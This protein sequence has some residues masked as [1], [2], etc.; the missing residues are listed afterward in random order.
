MIACGIPLPFQMCREDPTG[1][2]TREGGGML[3]SPLFVICSTNL[4]YL[5]SSA[6][7]MNTH[8]TRD[9]RDSPAYS[10]EQGESLRRTR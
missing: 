6:S 7:P 4:S 10:D 8:T 9:L 3:T 1:N 2:H 5:Y